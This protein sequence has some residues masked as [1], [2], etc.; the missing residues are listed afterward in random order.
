MNKIDNKIIESMHEFLRVKI[1]QKFNV[2][3]FK[4]LWYD[5]LNQLNDKIFKRDKKD[6]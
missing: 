1:P 3:N 5:N 4:E 2:K 6:K